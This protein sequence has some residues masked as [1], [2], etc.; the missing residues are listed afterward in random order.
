MQIEQK[1]IIVILVSKTVLRLQKGI[2][3]SINHN[4]EQAMYNS[5]EESTAFHLQ[6]SQESINHLI[7]AAKWGKF[8]A[9]LGFIVNVFIILAGIVISL[10]IKMFDDNMTSFGTLLNKLSP[11]ML[12]TIYILVG[13]IGLIPVITL[14]SFSNNVTR[15]LRNMDHATMTKALRQLGNFFTII[16]LYALIL[17]ALYIIFI[18]LIASAAMFAV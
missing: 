3:P 13:I 5:S 7:K 8:I 12:S 1:R 11:L 15:S 10:V 14:N 16:G 9:I 6:L 17:I 18:I 4:H 2:Q